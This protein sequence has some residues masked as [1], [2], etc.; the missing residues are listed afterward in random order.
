MPLDLSRPLVVKLFYFPGQMPARLLC[1]DLGSATP[2]V[3]A[4]ALAM[5]Q[6]R[7]EKYRRDG[8]SETGYGRLANATTPREGWVVVNRTENAGR[9]GT[10]SP[11]YDDRNTA[12]RVAEAS[13]ENMRVARV[14]WEEDAE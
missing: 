6:E 14:E 12:E 8:T 13:G 1:S 7:V 10:Y 2:I 5:G 9:W 4:V 3:V 11:V